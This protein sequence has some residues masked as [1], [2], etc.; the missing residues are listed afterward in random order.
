MRHLFLMDPI[1]TIRIDKD[2]TFALMF[3]AQARGHEVLHGPV[4]DLFLREADVRA[5]VQKVRLQKV[6]GEHAALGPREEV[7][8][9]DVDVVWMRKDPPFHMGYIF[10]TYLLDL[11]EARG[12]LVLNAPRGLRDMS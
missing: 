2:S 9:S 3:E 12:T 8:L 7:S 6:Q 10:N 5:V 11:A 1:E 4:P